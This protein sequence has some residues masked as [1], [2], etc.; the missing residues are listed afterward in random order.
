MNDPNGTVFADGVHHLYFQYNP[1][2]DQW[3]DIGWGHATSTDLVHWQELP[4]A[5][6]ATPTEMAFSGSMVLDLSNSSGLAPAGHS[7]PPMVALYTGF[8]PVTK[9]QSQCLAYSL[10]GGRTLVRYAGNPVLD[11]G[12]QEFR[13]P[14]VFWHAPTRRWAMLVAMALERQVWIYTSPNLIDWTQVSTFGP[15][16]SSEANIWEMPDLF[17]LPVTGPDG[18]A[19]VEKRWV[20]IVSVNGGSLWGGSGV[21]YFVGD[22][23]G[24]RFT[25]DASTWWPSGAGNAATLPPLAERTRWADFGRDFYAPMSFNH[26]PGG[27]VLWMGWMSNWA[28]ARELPTSPWRGQQSMARELSLVRTGRGL[29]L[30]QQPAPEVLAALPGRVVLDAHDLDA[31]RAMAL[32]RDAA[33]RSAT[34]RLQLELDRAG[35]T[36]PVTLSV[37]VGADERVQVGYDPAADGYFVQRGARVRRFSGDGERHTAARLSPARQYLDIDLWVDRSTIELF[38]DDGEIA[39]GDLAYNDPASQGVSLTIEGAAC[40]VRRLRVTLLDGAG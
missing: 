26:L 15:A 5:L 14:K 27:R 4:P 25:A 31:G 23:D 7:G 39:I 29:R 21:Q 11:I 6:A 32:L 18:S 36:G 16:G 2:G 3:G 20:L 35:L 22:F 34:L 8:H 24:E 40:R 13:D 30:R 37:L 33:L 28:Y 12:S 17:E 19:S 38:A 1:N 10:D 9:I